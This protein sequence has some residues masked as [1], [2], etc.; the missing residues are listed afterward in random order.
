MRSLHFA[1]VA[2]LVVAGRHSIATATPI[3]TNVTCDSVM[4]EGHAY[5]RV[6]FDVQNPD[7]RLGADHVSAS[8][9]P[10]TGPDDTCRVLRVTAPTGWSAGWGLGDQFVLWYAAS[11]SAIRLGPGMTLSGF[12]LVF[13][14]GHTRCFEFRLA[15]AV[16]EAF[17]IENDCFACDL[18]VPN[19]R[20]T[21]GALKAVYR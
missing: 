6:S 21:W 19:L 15:G 7:S 18:P 12:Q 13:T 16:D 11:D 17:A 20:R 3:V 9:L 10:S 1:L 14:P 8:R 5:P 2:V 4:I